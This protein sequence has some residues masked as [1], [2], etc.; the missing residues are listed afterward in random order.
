MADDNLFTE[1]EGGESEAKD[2]TFSLSR[3][4][5]A[6]AYTEANQGLSDKLDQVVNQMNQQ[7]QTQ[8]QQ[9]ATPKEPLTQTA[10]QNLVE[11]EKLWG[12]PKDY[13]EGVVK[14]MGASA[15]DGR[16]DQLMDT[17]AK[18]LWTEHKNLFDKEFGDGK[19]DEVIL[20]TLQVVSKDWTTDQLAQ[21]ENAQHLINAVRGNPEVF[22]QL[23][24]LGAEKKKTADEAKKLEEDRANT[25]HMMTGGQR[26]RPAGSKLA[27]DEQRT[28]DEMIKVGMKVTPETWTNEPENDSIDAWLKVQPTEKTKEGK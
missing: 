3:E 18:I 24:I 27:S 26:P 5:L 16:T 25:P 21:P 2:Q 14:R 19:W 8:Q 9:Q 11:A 12:G 13:I 17:A 7:T 23:V 1:G 4:D 22:P 6:G 28:H 10:E 15:K 20:P